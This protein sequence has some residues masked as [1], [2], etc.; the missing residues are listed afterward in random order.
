MGFKPTG[1]WAMIGIIGI[2]IL[3]I[4]A[5]ILI[6]KKMGYDPVSEETR[7]DYSSYSE[8]R[9]DVMMSVLPETEP[10]SAQNYKYYKH[11][12]E[13]SNTSE[14]VISFEVNKED[15]KSIKTYYDAQTVSN[16]EGDK[17]I[18]DEEITINF[19]ENEELSEVSQFISSQRGFTVHRYKRSDSSDRRYQEGFLYNE[20][21]GQVVI[22][23]IT[24]KTGQ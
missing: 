13:D 3:I 21:S 24:R 4:V 10:E 5:A 8:F 17:N 14:Y 6:L 7:T 1:K 9:E 19:L 23:D 16:A 20:D 18:K 22:F 15:L 11:I 2:V 12:N